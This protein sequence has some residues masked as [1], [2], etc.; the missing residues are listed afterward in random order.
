MSNYTREDLLSKTAT[1]NQLRNCVYHF[2]KFMQSNNVKDIKNRLRKMGT[3]I[4][5]TEI[6]LYKIRSNDPISLLRLI[7]SQIMNSKVEINKEGDNLYIVEDTKCPL[8]KYNR[9]DISDA[10]DEI[11][12]GMVQEFLKDN[13]FKVK[14]FGV[15][16]S[17]SLGAVT[18]V[19]FYEFTK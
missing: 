4:A 6:P 8:C 1:I 5:K 19:H 16:D 12:V 18:C 2:I 11:I 17:R 14:D 7:Y 9:E 15:K 10:P 13:G 3:N